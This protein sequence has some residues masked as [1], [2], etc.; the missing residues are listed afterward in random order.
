MLYIIFIF[1]WWYNS[2]EQK[3]SLSEEW[4]GFE[5]DG[6]QYGKT[7]PSLFAMRRQSWLA[8][9]GKALVFMGTQ[10]LAP[11]FHVEGS[12][13][14]RNCKIMSNGKGEVAAE[15]SRKKVKSTLVL[16]DD[17]FNLRVW[18]GFNCELIMAFIIVMDRICSNAYAPTLCAHFSLWSMLLILSFIVA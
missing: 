10:R 3:F 16:A 8:R 1:F 9:N 6:D 18:P 13:R 5:G 14:T 11:D 2:I 12:F 4:L 17:V 15:V 7:Q